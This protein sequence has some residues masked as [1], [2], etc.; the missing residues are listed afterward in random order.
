MYQGFFINL[1]SSM[2]R[3]HAL[4]RHLEEIG[5]AARYQRFEAVEGRAVAHLHPTTLEPGALGLW[6]SDISLLSAN[7]SSL[8]HLHIIEDDVTFAR[9]AVD[10]FERI[11]EHADA[12]LS[13]WDLVFTDVHMPADFETFRIF[14]DSMRNYWQTGNLAL[15]DLEHID[16]AGTTSFFVNKR[17]VAK[18]ADLLSGKWTAGA[19]I[20]LY[21]RQLVRQRS[22]K[23][24]V[25]LP[26]LTCGARHNQ[27]SDIRGGWDRSRRV[28]GIYRLGFFKDANSQALL[29]EMEEL[30]REA[31]V[32]P[33]AQLYLGALTFTLSDHFV[34]F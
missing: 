15:A 2:A 22:L 4:L 25:T 33:L 32:S 20:D 5:A 16:F 24:Y 7:R 3:R 29:A 14:F 12:R 28:W 30:T 23:A 27:E 17:S 10:L 1:S 19:P 26:F 8:L 21:I 13:H 9:N 34:P 31:K 6:L 18:L 11:L